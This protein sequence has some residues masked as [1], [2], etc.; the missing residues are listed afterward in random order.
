MEPTDL[1]TEILK[2][3]RDEIRGTNA[4]LDRFESRVEARFETMDARFEATDARLDRLH[5]RQ[6]DSEVRLATE[7][8]NVVAAVR[9]VRDELRSDR[10]LRARVDDH[11]HR[12]ERLETRT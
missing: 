8:I 1:T 6:V 11:E 4:R 9:E 7:L 10:A 5:Q 12:I 2:S 3:I